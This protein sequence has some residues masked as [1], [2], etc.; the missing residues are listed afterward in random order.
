MDAP[1]PT[2]CVPLIVVIGS[3]ATGKTRLAVELAEALNGEVISADS[4]QV[5]EGLDLVSAKPSPDE[6]SRVKHHL[7]SVVPTNSSFDVLAFIRAADACIADITSRGKLPILCGGTFYWIQAVLFESLL[8]H[9]AYSPPSSLTWAADYA[10]FLLPRSTADLHAAL[11]LID[12]ARAAEVSPSDS[13]KL[14]R[15]LETA[16]EASKGRLRHPDY[17]PPAADTTAAPA[18]E[19]HASHDSHAVPRQGIPG[20]DVDDDDEDA[21][22]AEEGETAS[23]LHSRY[24]GL[25]SP[26][27]RCGYRPLVLWLSADAAALRRRARARI[28]GMLRGAPTAEAAGGTPAEGTSA[29]GTGTAG[30]AGAARRSYRGALGE[31]AAG[32]ALLAPGGD[33]RGIDTTKGAAQAIGLKE[34]LPWLAAAAAAASIASPAAAVPPASTTC[35]ASAGLSSSA[36]ALAPSAA[37][38]GDPAAHLESASRAEALL[39]RPLQPGSAGRAEAQRA[40]EAVEAAESSEARCATVANA[41]LA[42]A[43]A[44]DAGATPAAAAAAAAAATAAAAPSATASAET[45]A[46]TTVTAAGVT[47]AAIEC[48]LAL[49]RAT[50][51]YAAVQTKGIRARLNRS[52]TGEG[53]LSL[54]P[55]L[56]PVSALFGAQQQGPL[57]LTQWPAAVVR[58]DSSAVDA[59]A[60][61]SAAVPAVTGP[62]DQGKGKDKGKGRGK[63]R[64]KGGGS[65]GSAWVGGDAQTA[66]LFETPDEAAQAAAE[67]ANAITTAPVADATAVLL[68]EASSV[69]QAASTTAAKPASGRQG[70][71]ESVNAPAVALARAFLGLNTYEDPCD[72]GRSSDCEQS[73]CGQS[74]KRPRLSPAAPVSAASVS[75][76]PAP[77]ALGC[78]PSDGEVRARV[79]A[80]LPRLPPLLRRHL[81]LPRCLMPRPALPSTALQRP[82]G[83]ARAETGAGTGAWVCGTCGG[84]DLLNEMN[85]VAHCASKGHKA[86]ERRAARTAASAA[87]AAAAV[88]TGVAT[89]V[90]SDAATGVSEGA[91]ASVS[92]KGEGK[93]VG[94][95]TAAPQQ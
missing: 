5:Y 47:A 56:S 83:A 16:A 49:E 57:P 42:A 50:L 23:S 75:A 1:T 88:T 65:D 18:N 94:A 91:G 74:V 95:A 22:F 21:P 48:S 36:A 60:P 62:Q 13:R 43:A 92:G 10:S 63:G 69:T 82:A 41:Y 70:W 84:R 90:R 2:G 59:P 73:D 30:G 51:L 26:R 29:G 6:C 33:V 76:A 45:A 12:P 89:A 35:E 25:T 85:Y 34:Y 28:A 40:L 67:A 46:E 58:V 53:A 17:T 55:L 39:G 37:A 87:T 31:V 71:S 52:L 7:V 11:L 24:G 81:L 20:N 44:V 4:M 3:T 9:F 79:G 72:R 93:G 61:A 27:L 86:N 54:L 8:P 66:K 32:A 14:R 64:G 78:Q 80:A 68:A 38:E 15:A 77:A 19:T